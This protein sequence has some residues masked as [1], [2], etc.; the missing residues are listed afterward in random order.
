[1]PTDNDITSSTTTT[2][3]N[4]IANND[5]NDTNH[6]IPLHSVSIISIFEFSI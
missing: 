2:N 4:H 6:T 3:N 5:D 1:M